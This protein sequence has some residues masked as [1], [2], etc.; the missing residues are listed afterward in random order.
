MLLAPAADTLA[1]ASG[2]AAAAAAAKSM[3][4]LSPYSFSAPTC[5]RSSVKLIGT[6][7]LQQHHMQ[8]KGVSGLLPLRAHP[9]F[10]ARA[11]HFSNK[12]A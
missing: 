7:P 11:Q 6:G 1:A 12:L 9:A 3:S 2:L 8:D 4:W 10:A 5:T